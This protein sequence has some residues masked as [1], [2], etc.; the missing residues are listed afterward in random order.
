M[1]RTDPLTRLA[2]H[3]GTDKYGQHLYT[4]VYDRLFS[5]LRE[6]PVRLLEIGIG[7]PQVSVLGGASLRM[8]RDYFPFGRIVGLDLQPKRLDLGPRVTVV[9]GSQTDTGLLRSL[10]AAYGPFDIVIDDGSHRVGD[11]L[12]SFET[13]YPLL[14]DGALY[15]VEDTQTAYWPDFGGTAGAAG[16]IMSRTHEVVTAM[17]ALEASAAGLTPVTETFGELTVSVQVYRNLVVFE[18][19]ANVYPSNR[20]LQIGHPAVRTVLERLDDERARD[21]SAGEIVTRIGMLE[22]AGHPQ[23]ALEEAR[24]GLRAHPDSIALLCVL[25]HLTRRFGLLDESRAA[26][27]RMLQ[28][29]PDEPVFLA[30]A[31]QMRG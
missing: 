13:L 28:A 18:R 6:Q 19:G 16:T 17:H 23:D 30:I 22:V 9:Q 29:V 3:H 26:L 12:T 4:P 11:V 10:H 27:E 15:A 14:S 2:I 7:W 1:D 24:A 5:H 8:W 31:Q 20:G 25:Q 21:P